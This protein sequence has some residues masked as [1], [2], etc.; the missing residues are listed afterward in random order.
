MKKARFTEG[1]IVWIFGQSDKR[2]ADLQTV[3]TT[4][5]VALYC[6]TN[7]W[8]RPWRGGVI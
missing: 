4:N 7:L 1:Q 8:G 2:E 5:N 6:G 3:I